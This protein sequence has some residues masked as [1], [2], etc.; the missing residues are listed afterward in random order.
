MRYIAI[1]VNTPT[2]RMIGKN[3]FLQCIGLSKRSDYIPNE[4]NTYIIDV[5]GK[6]K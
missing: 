6:S 4:N 5:D 2:L 1:E 3:G